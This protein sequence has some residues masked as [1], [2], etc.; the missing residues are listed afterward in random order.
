MILPIQFKIKDNPYY[1]RYLR[2][3][4]EWYKILNRNPDMFKLFEDEAKKKY[5]ITP[6]DKI[7]NLLNTL[8]MFEKIVSTFKE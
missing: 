4:S 3:N 8:Q 6:E 7:K 2:S 1:L 5:H